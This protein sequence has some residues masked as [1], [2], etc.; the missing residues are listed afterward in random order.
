[1][2]DIFDPE[3]FNINKEFYKG[4]LVLIDDIPEEKVV[5][6]PLRSETP[7]EEPKVEGAKDGE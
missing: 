4:E 3:V 6:S 5:P 2:C 7:T 1:M